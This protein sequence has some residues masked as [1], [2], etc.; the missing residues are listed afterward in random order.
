[1]TNDRSLEVLIFK[2]ISWPFPLNTGKIADNQKQK[3]PGNKAEKLI[4][5]SFILIQID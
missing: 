4:S 1:M 3:T 2:V 5:G